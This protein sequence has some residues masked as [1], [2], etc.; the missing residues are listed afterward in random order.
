MKRSTIVFLLAILGL[1]QGKGV[2]PVFRADRDI[3]SL[4]RCW[5]TEYNISGAAMPCWH[6]KYDEDSNEKL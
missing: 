2:L 1:S 3:I 5:Q 6:I 4:T